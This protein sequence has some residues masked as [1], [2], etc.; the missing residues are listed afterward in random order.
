M[1]HGKKYL[2]SLKKYDVSTSYDLVSAADL[3]KK[4][5]FAKFDE[6]VDLSVKL[7]LKKSQSV[8]DTVVLPHQFRGEKKV[9]VFCKS[10]KE[11]EAL[12]AGATYVGSDDLIEKVKGGW[13]D[14]DIAVATPDMMKDVGKLGMVL[15]RKGLMP[16][17]KTG[18]VTFDLKGAIAELKKGRVE[19][20]AD[21]TGVVHLPVG[22][23]SM[24]PAKIA[25]NVEAVLAEIKR[26]RP[27]DAKGDF[28]QSVSI[29]STM[30]PGVWVALKDKE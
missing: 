21:K 20:R 16:N 10:E 24:E 25:E 8:R 4:L 29:S 14:F 19:F 7:N 27:A 5:A 18:T 22:K 12:E 23:V 13:L 9:L 1:K 11:K 2:E 17:P 30:G 26:K 3:V 15:G 28:I 6:T